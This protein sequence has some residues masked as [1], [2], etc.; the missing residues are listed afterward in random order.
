MAATGSVFEIILQWSRNKPDWQRDA[1]RR[2][3]A[4]RTLDADDHQELALLCKRGCG[5]PGR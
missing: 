2:I 1:L 4:K 5:F 3:V